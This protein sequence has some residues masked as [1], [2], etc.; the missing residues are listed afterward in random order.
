MPCKI[1]VTQPRRL[2]CIALAKRVAAELGEPI[3]RSVGYRIRLENVEPTSRGATIVFCTTGLLL[4][5]LMAADAS[6]DV[7][8]LLLDEVHERDLHCDFLLTVLRERLLPATPRLKLVLMS[9]TVDEQKFVRY[10][11]GPGRCGHVSV[12][13]RCSRD[14]TQCIRTRRIS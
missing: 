3:G 11:G 1:V 7:T 8:H 12:P 10:Y 5:Q 6:A 9:A 2:A 14:L 13:G 4:R